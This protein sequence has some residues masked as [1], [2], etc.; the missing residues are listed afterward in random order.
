[1]NPFDAIEPKRVKLFKSVLYGLAEGIQKSGLIFHPLELA[2][3]AEEFASEL[4]IE[5]AA[6]FKR[7]HSNQDS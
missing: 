4:R 3:A 2:T 1:M 6:Q 5:S 7:S